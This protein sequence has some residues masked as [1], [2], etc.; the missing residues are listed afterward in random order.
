[1]ALS[2]VKED[3]FQ[4]SFSKTDDDP[5]ARGKTRADT[6]ALCVHASGPHTP[7]ADP[8]LRTPPSLPPPIYRA[9]RPDQLWDPGPSVGAQTQ[10]TRLL[11]PHAQPNRGRVFCRDPQPQGH[12]EK[13]W[14]SLD[15][16]EVCSER[17]L[18]SATGRAPPAP[19]TSL[20]SERAERGPPASW[21]DIYLERPSTALMN[22]DQLTRGAASAWGLCA[23]R[24][25]SGSAPPGPPNGLSE[26]VHTNEHELSLCPS[27]LSNA[28][29]LPAPRPLEGDALALTHPPAATPPFWAPDPRLP[30]RPSSFCLPLGATPG[31][32]PHPHGD[33]SDLGAART[34][35]PELSPCS[36]DSRD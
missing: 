27:D 2:P 7:L 5:A 11:S 24:G 26:G 10:A 17:L 13:L 6:R 33:T 1:M 8:I 4:V 16:V 3:A 35:Q 19:P 22:P 23:I 36:C 25:A 29:S 20:H 28:R 30:G 18:M 31:L 34:G 14:P 32:H 21:A 15:S 9:D 12:T